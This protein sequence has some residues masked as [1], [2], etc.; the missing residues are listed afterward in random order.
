MEER[1]D[2]IG[3]KDQKYKNKLT[4]RT[5]KECGGKVLEPEMQRWPHLEYLLPA[6]SKTWEMADL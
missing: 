4:R 6:R 1:W 2:D 5:T 3:R